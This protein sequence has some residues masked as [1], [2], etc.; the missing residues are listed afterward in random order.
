MADSTDSSAQN[1]AVATVLG[2]IPS[3]VFILTAAD[4]EGHE[5]GMLASW[6]QQ[7]AFEPPLISV[8]VNNSRYLNEWFGKNP[9]AALSLVGKAQ[10]G[11]FFKQFGKGFEPDEQAFEGF[12]ITRGTTGVPL[13]AEAMGSLEGRITSSLPAGDHTIYLIQVENAVPGPALQSD[14]PYVHIRKTG[15]NY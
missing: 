8:A 7:A 4:G 6:V 15:F 3:G 10:S 14:E 2:K 11:R 5:T 12:E 1:D 13:L 9:V